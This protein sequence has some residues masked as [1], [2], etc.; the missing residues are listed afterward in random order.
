[1]K[2]LILHKAI[3]KALFYLT[4]QVQPVFEKFL[5]TQFADDIIRLDALKTALNNADWL[6]DDGGHALKEMA[7][8]EINFLLREIARTRNEEWK[9]SRARAEAREIARLKNLKKK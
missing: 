7:I 9:T 4:S 2:T 3:S 8:N 1:M 6:E 5:N